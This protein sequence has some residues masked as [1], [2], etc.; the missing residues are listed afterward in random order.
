VV[1]NDKLGGVCVNQGCITVKAW[2]KAAEI[3][4]RISAGEAFGSQAAVKK[5]DFKT[6][7]DNKSSCSKKIPAG[8][9]GF[10]AE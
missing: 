3:L 1:E 8:H 6:I 2:L 9:G 5:I 4:R 7:I 10:S